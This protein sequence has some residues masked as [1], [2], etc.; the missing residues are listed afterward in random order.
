MI[1][2]LTEMHLLEGTLAAKG[3]DN[4]DDRTNVYYYNA[5]FEKY[6]ITQTQF[7]SSIVWYNKH[8]K[9]FERIYLKVEDRLATLEEKVIAG[10]FHPN[11]SL[12]LDT[13]Q[14]WNQPV[15]FLLAKDSTRTNISFSIR[16]SGL[17]TNDI[18]TLRFLVRIAPEDSCQQRYALF[19]VH[20]ADGATDSIRS[21][22]LSDSILR[23]YTLRI[24]PRRHMKIDSLTGFLL[25]TDSCNGKLNA[26]VDSI[27]FT[28]VINPNRIDSIK[29][30]IERMDSLRHDTLQ[31]AEPEI[32]T[33]KREPKKDL[34]I[35]Q[36]R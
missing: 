12:P 21:L 15:R 24:T 20:Y 33:Q 8:P 4:P 1:E 30:M 29:Q 6:G 2:L 22:Q 31:L 26:M 28:R 17:L 18:Y 19:K 10:Y 16:E 35:N 9:S 23:R 3:M 36:D 5:L 14:M 34:Q 27:S 13:I 7:D 32:K 25:A 11:D